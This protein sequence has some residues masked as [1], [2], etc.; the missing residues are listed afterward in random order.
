MIFIGNLIKDF[1][2]GI[3]DISSEGSNERG[4]SS[5][6]HVEHTVVPFL[7]VHAYSLERNH[8]I[9]CWNLGHF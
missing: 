7:L 4:V 3:L 2:E 5:L 6:V 1:V 9:K 8:S